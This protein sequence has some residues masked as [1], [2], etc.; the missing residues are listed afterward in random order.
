M[1]KGY[2]MLGRS[3][4]NGVVSSGLSRRRKGYRRRRAGSEGR[5]DALV[6]TRGERL[7]GRK[8]VVAED[9][10]RCFGATLARSTVDDHFVGLE[11]VARGRGHFVHNVATPAGIP[12]GTALHGEGKEGE[13]E[14]EAAESRQHVKRA[15]RAC[16]FRLFGDYFLDYLEKLILKYTTEHKGFSKHQCSNRSAECLAEQQRTD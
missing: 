3:A 12:A 9:L 4:G 11:A 8:F 16:S 14:E 7:V 1:R 13:G 2:Y 5:G 15:V 6:I 10:E